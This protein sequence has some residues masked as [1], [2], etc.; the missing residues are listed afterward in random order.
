[1][2]AWITR[3]NCVFF[4][5]LLE[6]IVFSILFEL[7]ILVLVSP[8][9]AAAAV[10]AAADLLVQDVEDVQADHHGV[11]HHKHY[12]TMKTIQTYY[13]LWRNVVADCT[14]GGVS[15]PLGLHYEAGGG[16]A[17]KVAHVEGERPHAF[18]RTLDAEK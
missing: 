8:F 14:R 9:R 10:A 15:E 12:L 11:E 5:S 1:M 18:I 2:R 4:L 7:L 6:L 17:H 16:G 3:D 13:L